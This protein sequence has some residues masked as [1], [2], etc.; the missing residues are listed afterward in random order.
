MNDIH[1]NTPQP[2]ST[3]TKP[4]EHIKLLCERL[5]G[6]LYNAPGDHGVLEEQVQ[7]LNA[8]FHATLAE[9]L[10]LGK[11]RHGYDN[12]HGWLELA[13]KIQKQCTDTVRTQKAIDYMNGLTSIQTQKL[14][15]PTPPL[16]K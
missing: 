12:A 16:K 9:Q 2:S 10:E 15:A 1:K 11:N 7:V 4:Q 3:A 6:S 13:L 8:L 5:A 14:N